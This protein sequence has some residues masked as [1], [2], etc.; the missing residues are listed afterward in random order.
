M[1]YGMDLDFHRAFDG[2]SV[3]IPGFDLTSFIR[4][5]TALPKAK[6]VLAS[7]LLSKNVQDIDV[8]FDMTTRPKTI[9]GCLQGADA[10]DFLLVIPI[11]VLGQHMS[12]V[13][14]CTILKYWL[15]I[16]LFCVDEVRPV[17]RKA[18]LDTFGE[19]TIHCKELP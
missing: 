16:P 4:K 18:C 7:A 8:K 11:D 14:Y 9:F 17:S 2:L 6:H 13:E 1:I 5:D 19:H 3:V 10:Q 12:L 15:M